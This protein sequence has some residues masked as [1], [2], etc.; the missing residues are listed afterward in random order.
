MQGN[1]IRLS[2]H[3]I[4]YRNKIQKN[5]ETYLEIWSLIDKIWHLKPLR[6]WRKKNIGKK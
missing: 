4:F 5:L 1:Y 3:E 6:L 2:P